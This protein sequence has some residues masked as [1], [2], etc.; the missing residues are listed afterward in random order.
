MIEKLNRRTKKAIIHNL[1]KLIKKY[2]L[3]ETRLVINKY[4]EQIRDHKKLQTEIAMREN[5]IDRIKRRLVIDG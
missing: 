2:G 5:E 3:D 4:F 1:E